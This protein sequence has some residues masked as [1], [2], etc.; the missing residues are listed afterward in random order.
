MAFIGSITAAVKR[1]REV[2]G[3][4]LKIEVEVGNFKD[5]EEAIVAGADI[6]MLDNMESD[7]IMSCSRI[8]KE[9]YGGKNILLEASG[10]ITTENIANYFIPRKQNSCFL[11]TNILNP[12]IVVLDLD[13]ISIGGLTQSVQ[14][15]DY[16]MKLEAFGP[17]AQK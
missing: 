8:I 7:E 10:G 16:S 1:A 5:L 12:I 2:C 9:K 13:V 6:V 17:F 11:Y 4:S 15:V 14:H 3:F